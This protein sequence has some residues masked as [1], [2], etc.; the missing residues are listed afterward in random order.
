MGTGDISE[1]F[2]PLLSLKFFVTVME[3]L[4]INILHFE[5]QDYYSH[6]KYKQSEATMVRSRLNIQ[7]VF[8]FQTFLACC[9]E[10]PGAWNDIN[11]LNPLKCHTSTLSKDKK[12]LFVSTTII[13]HILNAC[14]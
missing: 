11:K 7:N 6:S 10:E 2:A 5:R 13:F 1:D 3:K 9:T 4:D 12:K 14:T 8:L